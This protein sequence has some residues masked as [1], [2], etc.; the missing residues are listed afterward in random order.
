[1]CA[2]RDRKVIVGFPAHGNGKRKADAV[3]GAA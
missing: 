1:L 2:K 3:A